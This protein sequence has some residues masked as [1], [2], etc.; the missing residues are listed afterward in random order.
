MPGTTNTMK[1]TPTAIA[2]R[3]ARP[4]NG[5]ATERPVDALSA[6]LARSPLAWASVARTMPPC[7][8]ADNTTPMIADASTTA[9]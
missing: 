9:P 7:T 5:K 3:I 4:T 8:R 1:P 6:K 2:I